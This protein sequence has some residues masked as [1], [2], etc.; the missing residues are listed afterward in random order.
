LQSGCIFGCR[1]IAVANNRSGPEL[2]L[3]ARS[4]LDGLR[5]PYGSC[6]GDTEECDLADLAQYFGFSGN[7]ITLNIYSH[8]VE[9][10][11]TEAAENVR[12]QSSVGSA[13]ESD[14]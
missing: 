4:P 13:A 2:L 5:C 6:G 9:G 14:Y 7:R 12:R 3:I 11:Q 1:W 8:V 10:M